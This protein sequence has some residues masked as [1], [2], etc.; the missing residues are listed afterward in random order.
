MRDGPTLLDSLYLEENA[1]SDDHAVIS[2]EEQDTT[3][4]LQQITTGILDDL[5]EPEYEN[6][7]KLVGQL[8]EKPLRVGSIYSGTDFAWHA[9]K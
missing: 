9:L 2:C 8:L 3:E 7:C 6:V 1:F 4:I 5:T